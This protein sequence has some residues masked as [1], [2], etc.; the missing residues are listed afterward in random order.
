M[1]RS[2][3]AMHLDERKVLLAMSGGVDSAVAASLLQ[4]EGYEVLGVFL[5][6]RT[7]TEQTRSSGPPR[8]QSD[9]DDARRVALALGIHLTSLPVREALDPIIEN[10]VS[11]YARGRTPNPCIHCNTRIKFGLLFDLADSMGA[12]Y[13]GTGH[14]ARISRC[15]GDPAILRSRDSRKD[16]SYALFAIPRERLGR[17]LLP[18]GQLGSKEDVRQIARRLRLPVSEKPE[19]QDICF[20]PGDGYVSMLQDRAPRALRTGKIVT[21]DGRVLGTH[22]GYARFTI[23]QRRGLGVADARPLYVTQIDPS[24]ATITAGP[25]EELMGNQLTALRANWQCEV[26]DEFPA[27]VQIRYNQTP[28]GGTVR[29]CGPERFEIEFDRPVP[30][31][32]PGQA[33][34]VY[35]GDRLLGGG[36]IEDR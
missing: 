29:T 19:S 17:V 13:V 32:T 36:W 3:K 25:R 20:A 16:Q 11:E 21:S 34:V 9:S 33:A 14:H 31:I 30:A 23:G 6:L 7:A 18:I 15:G 10:F 28:V 2:E 5:C 4:Q 8:S 27:S 12:K 22:D 35:Q 1:M 24:T 26:P